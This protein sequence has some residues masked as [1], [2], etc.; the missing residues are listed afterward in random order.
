[1]AD[2]GR[3][4]YENAGAVP[5]MPTAYCMKSIPE[6]VTPFC[7][8]TFCS[9]PRAVAG[10]VFRHNLSSRVSERLPVRGLM[11]LQI[12]ARASHPARPFAICRIRQA[13]C[14]LQDWKLSRSAFKQILSQ[15]M[16]GRP[17]GQLTC[18]AKSANLHMSHPLTCAT[19]S[20]GDPNR[21]IYYPMMAQK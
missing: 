7:L 4:P 17:S 14:H 18:V 13:I 1:M 21:R 11:Q 3:S 12:R 2:L 5:L 6:P 19:V 20:I 8:A 16:Y 9:T 15:L 10:Q